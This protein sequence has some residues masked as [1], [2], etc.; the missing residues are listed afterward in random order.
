L[1]P[2]DLQ[3]AAVVARNLAD[4]GSCGRIR[5]AAR[6]A[7]GREATVSLGVSDLEGKAL[8][9]IFAQSLRYLRETLFWQTVIFSGRL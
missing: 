7:G 6:A 4:S 8:P 1:V 2:P 3:E 5:L 9:L